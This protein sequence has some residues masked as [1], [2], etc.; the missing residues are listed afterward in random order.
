MMPHSQNSASTPIPVIILNWNGLED[1]CRCLDHLLANR[2]VALRA[3]VIDNG[4]DSSNDVD[5]LTK[6]YG[7]DPRVSIEANAQNLGFARGMNK[8]LQA[9]LD[10]RRDGPESQRP[11]YVALLNNDAFVEDGWLAALRDRAEKSNAG[12]VAS[13][14]LREDQP[15]L[16][17]NAGHIFLNTGEVL[18]RGGGQPAA[19]YRDA[20][21]VAGACGGACLLRLDMLEELGVFDTFY[22]TGYE[23]AEFGLRALIAGW[24]QY[25]EPAARVRHR[26]GAS[27]D[28]IRDLDYAIT[29]QVNINY[30]YV[31]LMPGTVVLMNLPWLALKTLALLTMPILL[32]RWRLARVQWVALWRST[33]LL[34]TMLAARRRRPAATIGSRAV[35]RS[36]VFFFGTYWRYFQ[37]FVWR[38][39]PTI[40]ER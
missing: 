37:R 4:S 40:F 7:S 19:A 3:I 35:L 32:G 38:R 24:P 36:Q 31:K 23:D 27:I 29:L 18:P 6:R 28:R 22:S 1:T 13:C 9:L 33:L 12:A 17:D 5:V 30:A 39:E 21:P 11:A 25:Y 26:I 16:L 10:D 8:A 14:M 2:G 20:A 15:E 34:P